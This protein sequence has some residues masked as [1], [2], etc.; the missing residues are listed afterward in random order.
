[1]TGARKAARERDIHQRRTG[2]PEQSRGFGQPDMQVRRRDGALK[3]G[4][5]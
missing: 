4:P 2:F 3:I 5:E 1:M